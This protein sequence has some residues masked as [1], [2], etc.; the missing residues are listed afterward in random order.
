MHELGLAL[1]IVTDP[2]SALH[3]L[4]AEWKRLGGRWSAADIVHFSV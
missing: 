2:E 4:G 1:D 3:T